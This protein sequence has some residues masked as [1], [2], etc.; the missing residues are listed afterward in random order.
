MTRVAS[1]I[2]K[3]QNDEKH[4]AISIKACNPERAAQRYTENS[5]N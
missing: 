5:L 2:Y 3:I 4:F 1:R